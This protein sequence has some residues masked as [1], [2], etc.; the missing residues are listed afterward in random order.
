MNDDQEEVLAELLKAKDV[1][2][3][4]SLGE[5][6]GEYAFQT[7]DLGHAYVTLNSDYRS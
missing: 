1:T 2:V 5:G 7:S 3:E 6:P 4:I